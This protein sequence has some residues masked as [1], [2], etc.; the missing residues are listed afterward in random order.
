[1]PAP[2]LF[3]G[4]VSHEGSSFRISQGPEGLGAQLAAAIPGAS[5][6]VNTVDA[7][8]QE[9]PL[10]SAS[11]VQAAL[12]AERRLEAS[13]ARY[14]E[15]P[16]DMRWW[17]SRAYRWALRGQQRLRPPAPAMLRRLLNIELSH[18]TLMRE[19]RDS[20][21]PWSLIIE[22]DAFSS[23]ISD[24]S[25]GLTSLMSWADGPDFVNLSESFTPQELGIRHLLSPVESHRWEGPASRTIFEA[26]KPVTNTV[27]AILYSAP[28]L[29]RLVTVLDALPMEPVVPIDWKLNQAI[30]S[31]H[32][33]GQAQA[34]KCWLV[35]PAPI[36]QM[37]MHSPEILPS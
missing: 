11:A 14:L 18:L 20:G 3:I 8:P 24:L 10:V 37:S 25:R 21:A 36:R 33:S 22:D 26:R 31:M 5:V 17:R 34:G 32:A 2:P 29:Q 1:M 30:M 23:D 19:G 4:V 28:F 35:E 7:L 16:T 9:S 12:V 13:W 27:C 15:R 6:R